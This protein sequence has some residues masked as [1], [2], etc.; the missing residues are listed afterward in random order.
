MVVVQ[1]RQQRTAPAV[2]VDRAP[3]PGPDLG[4]PP[5]VDP[6]IHHHLVALDLNVPDQHGG[7]TRFRTSASVAAQ[8]AMETQSSSP[9]PAARERAAA[10]AANTPV[11]GSAS[12]SPR[13]TGSPF[14]S[15]PVSPCGHGSVVSEGDTVVLASVSGDADPHPTG[16]GCEELLGAEAESA[17]R[18]WP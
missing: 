4:D 2:H 13:N 7:W 15:T 9:P 16:P 6:Y 5:T 10:W 17:Q 1:A 14:A 18:A 11:T 12:A 8:A 3:Q